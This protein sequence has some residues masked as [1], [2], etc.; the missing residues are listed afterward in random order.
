MNKITKDQMGI[1]SFKLS[2]VQVNV[3]KFHD[4]QVKSAKQFFES[5]YNEDEWNELEEWATKNKCKDYSIKDFLFVLEGKKLVKFIVEMQDNLTAMSYMNYI[6]SLR[7]NSIC[8]MLTDNNIW[9]QL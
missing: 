1:K 9:M 3:D 7:S 5:S 8:S 6:N 2:E 4:E